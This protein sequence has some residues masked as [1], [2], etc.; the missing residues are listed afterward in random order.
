MLPYHL[1]SAE[2]G[3]GLYQLKDGR[4]R[5]TQ[6]GPITP[7]MCGIDYVL[8]ERELA[9]FLQSLDLPGVNYR[10]AIIWDGKSDRNHTT[11]R[12]LLIGQ[13]F[14]HGQINDLD[15]AGERMLLMSNQHV[16]VSPSLKNTL[17]KT[18]FGYLSFSEGL[19][20]FFGHP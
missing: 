9:D 4:F 6:A 12:Q 8:A 19:S 15:L 11:H 13:H 2:Y 5:L 16:F 18:G 7:L 20:D 14:S 17:E 10:D 3:V 1:Q